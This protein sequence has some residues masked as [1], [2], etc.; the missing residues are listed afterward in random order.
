MRLSVSGTIS[1]GKST[2]IKDFL[3]EWSMYK[4][5]SEDYRKLLKDK[6]YPHSKNCTKEGQWAILNQM[7]DEM[8]KYKP[9]D[10][11]IFDRCPLDNLV[12]SLWA[13]EKGLGGIDKEFIDKCIPIVRESMKYLDIIYFIPITKVSPIKIEDNGVRETDP[14]YI[15]E[16]DHIFKALVQQY[17][18]NLDSTPFFDSNDCPAII[19]VFG[20]PLERIQ[21][22]KLYLNADGNIIGEEGGSVL[23]P[24]NIDEL[25]KIILQQASEH[26]KEEY[27]KKQKQMISDF[28]NAERKVKSKKRK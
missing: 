21:L 25:E 14:D 26:K 23:D 6:N 16:I 8:Q 10:Y 27:Y 3:K 19:E 12:F 17:Q 2:L 15:E 9:E 22:L 11:V 24:N 20:K 18:R 5:P 1:I 4:T 7:I 28:E 13:M